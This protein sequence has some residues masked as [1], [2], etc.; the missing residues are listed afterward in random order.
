MGDVWYLARQGVAFQGHEANEENLYHLMK[1][2]A[3]DDNVLSSWLTC[4]HDY[5]SPQCQNVYLTCLVTQ[6][7]EALQQQSVVQFS[8]IVDGTQDILLKEHTSIRHVDHDL[9]P[10]EVFVE[11]Y[12]VPVTNGEQIAKLAIDVLLGLNIQILGLQGQT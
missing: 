10:Q 2:F 7:S 3:N 5:A 4:C 8:V 9:M 12:E 6:L 1:L 11:L